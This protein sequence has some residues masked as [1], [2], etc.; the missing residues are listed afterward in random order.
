MNKN[1]VK[2]YLLK[3]RELM[4]KFSHYDKGNLYYTIQLEDG[5]Y[6]LPIAAFDGTC[7]KDTILDDIVINNFTHYISGN[8]YY[9]VNGE[10]LSVSISDDGDTL[11]SDLGTTSFDSEIKASFLNRWVDKAIESGEFTKL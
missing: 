3:N 5:V 6:N 1:E 2:K 11:S 10:Q 4:A 7:K 8:F 9:E